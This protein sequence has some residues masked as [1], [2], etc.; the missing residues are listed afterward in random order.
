MRLFPAG[1][2]SQS[3]AGLVGALLF[4]GAGLALAGNQQYEPMSASV[5]SS[6]AASIAERG[7]IEPRFASPVHKADWL[8]AM[9]G[10][11]PARWKPTS[12]QRVEFLLAARYEAQRSGL[13]PHLV[14]GLIEVE[15]NFRRYAVSGAGAR[16]YMQVMPFWTA[17][18]GDS[19]PGKLFS[20]RTNLRY[21]CTI[22]RHYLDLERGDLF[23]ALGRYNGS[24]G[25]PEYPAA[26]LKAWRKWESRAAA[27]QLSSSGAR[28]G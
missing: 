18:I 7:D 24:L 23:R 15:S 27:T 14:L 19:D 16:G 22:L 9:S 20:M 11:L 12:R 26:V 5:R 2:R 21:G 1:V 25:H 17:L 8:V 6:L 10:G 28:G 13:D 3:L 4:A